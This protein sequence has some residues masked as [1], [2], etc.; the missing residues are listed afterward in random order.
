MSKVIVITGAG[1]G[2]GKVLARHFSNDGDKVVLLGRTPS[3]VK[4]LAEELGE[5]ALAIGCDIGNS[6]SV[7]L[8]FTKIA[9]NHGSI[10][11][12]INNATVNDYST[13]ADASDEHILNTVA[14]NM[15][16]NLLCT[17]AAFKLMKRG[18]HVINVSSESVEI[19]YPLHTV[20]QAT[21]GGIE[22]MS[23]HLQEEVRDRGFRVSVVRAGVMKG[24]DRTVHAT[25]EAENEFVRT[26]SARGFDLGNQPA[27]QYSSIYW[28][29][30]S[31][32]DMPADMH[33]DTVRFHA[34]KP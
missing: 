2:L 19:S 12:L 23:T 4:A 7:Q 17:R 32:V 13:L 33:V 30:R 3:K 29:F 16:G 10:D 31:L 34:R 14:T 9:Q 21:K 6:E 26:A 5:P 20:Y 15:T 28:V 8:A 18:G 11:V 27:A 24:E 22:I 25:K 1:A